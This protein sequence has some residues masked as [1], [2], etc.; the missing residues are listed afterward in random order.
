MDGL[1]ILLAIG[2]GVVI[3][4]AIKG[5]NKVKNDKLSEG[6]RLAKEALERAE[7]EGLEI[8]KIDIDQSDL[9]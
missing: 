1:G 6:E 3:I 7:R 8:E 5:A 2:I 9:D 4:L